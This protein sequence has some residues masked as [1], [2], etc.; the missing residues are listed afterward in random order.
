MSIRAIN[1]FLKA[2]KKDIENNVKSHATISFN[3]DSWQE[4]VT[5]RAENLAISSYP[6]IK[7][8]R[9]GPNSFPDFIINNDYG[10]EVKYS[11]TGE[12]KT[13]G[14]SI[15]ES[16]RV[17][18][19][20]NFI[21]F[22]SNRDNL[23][24][25]IKP[26]ENC[27]AGIKSTH[28]PRYEIDMTLGKNQGILKDIKTTYI[29]FNKLDNKS[30]I[31]SLRNHIKKVSPH[32]QL[33]WW[34]D[35]D[36]LS[37]VRFL[38]KLEKGEREKLISKLF[39][40]QPYILDKTDLERYDKLSHFL[41]KEYSIITSN[42]RDFFT[43]GGRGEITLKDTKLN[44]SKINNN[45]YHRANEIKEVLESLSDKELQI[46]YPEFVKLKGRTKSIEKY[47]LKI[48][49]SYDDS[50]PLIYREGIKKK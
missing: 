30:K 40:V 7:I 24:I 42:L 28:Y 18:T 43:A 1:L 36:G 15:L 32:N 47:Y 20:R 8:D 14:N 25:I 33:P 3:G 50:L 31:K 2:L 19:S 46:F 37:S 11:Q 49:E 13:L 16:N 10:V 27:L 38:G 39:A 21:F 17:R 23:E 34:V 5:Y 44:L 45:F 29:K 26:Y 35:P 6:D 12:Y 48:L 22:G 41:L 4:Y 9:C